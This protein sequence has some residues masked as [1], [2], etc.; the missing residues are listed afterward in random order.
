M[1]RNIW[2]LDEPT[3]NLDLVGKEKFLELLTSHLE[4]GGISIIATHE[5]SQFDGN[6]IINLGISI[7]HKKRGDVNTAPFRYYLMF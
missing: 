2:L 5:P 4:T 6:K 1:K 7:I 3:T